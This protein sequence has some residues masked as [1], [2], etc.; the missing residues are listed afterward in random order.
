[1]TTQRRPTQTLQSM[2]ALEEKLGYEDRAVAGGLDKF[3][4]NVLRDGDQEQFFKR[5]VAALPQQGYAALSPAERRSWAS[6]VRDALR[7]GAAPRAANR[8]RQVGTC[9]ESLEKKHP[10]TRTKPQK[11]WTNLDKSGHQNA[12]SPVVDALPPPSTTKIPSPA[13]SPSSAV[14]FPSRAKP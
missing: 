3:L 6:D 14:S 13:T 10:K 4:R 11:I 8:P 1:M 2:L 7:P 9:A 12:Q 5:I